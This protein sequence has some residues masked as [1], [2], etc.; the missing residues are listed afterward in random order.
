MPTGSRKAKDE[1]GE[2]NPKI[3]INFILREYEFFQ[4]KR[5]NE[6]W[7]ERKKNI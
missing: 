6:R 7:N 2:E 3:L 1:K 4:Q 5:T